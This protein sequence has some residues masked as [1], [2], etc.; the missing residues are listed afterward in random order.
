MTLVKF[1]QRPDKTGFYLSSQH[2]SPCV[3]GLVG[4]ETPE[5]LLDY[6]RHQGAVDT[7]EQMLNTYSCSVASGRWEMR[8]FFWLLDVAYFNA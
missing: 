1:E 6:S 7:M 8:V 4:S 5:I 3:T 2:D